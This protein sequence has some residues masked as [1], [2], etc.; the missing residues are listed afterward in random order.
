MELLNLLIKSLFDPIV[1][2]LILIAVGSFFLFAQRNKKSQRIFFLLLFLILYGA[3]IPPVSNLLSYFLEN[4]YFF[5]AKSNID[6][7]DIVVVLGGGVSDN[8]YLKEAMPSQ[9]TA[10]RILY[11]VQAFN[12]NGANYLVCSGK[13]NGRLS[14]A[15]V[16]GI[17][18]ERLGV[19]LDKIKLDTESQNTWEHAVELSKIFID[20]DLK[21]GLVTSAYH[22]KRSEREF[23]KYFT[24]VIPLPSDYLYSSPPLS[25]FTFFPNSSCL[26]KSSMVIRE[27][28]GLIWYKLRKA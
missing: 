23:R 10:S 3:S 4:N 22:M 9:K 19:P 17:N 24:H 12:K 15:E 6:E 8:K 14:E 28:I 5:N 11:A 21:I 25:I 16:M 2:V 18:A 20:K 1:F 7:L 26:Y 13:G 27:M